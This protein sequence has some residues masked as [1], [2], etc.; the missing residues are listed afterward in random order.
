[1]LPLDDIVVEEC[2]DKVEDDTAPDSDV[3]PHCP[4]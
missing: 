3:V 1:M 2:E 4:V